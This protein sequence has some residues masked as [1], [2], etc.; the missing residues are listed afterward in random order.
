MPEELLPRM[1]QIFAE[2]KLSVDDAEYVVV[3][4]LLEQVEA[5]LALL[6][7]VAE[8]FLAAVV[9]KDEVTL[10]LP[11]EAWEPLRDQADEFEEARGYR[12]ITFDLPADLGVVGFIATLSSLLAEADVSLFSVSAYTRDHMLVQEEDLDQA[13]QVLSDFIQRC[14]DA[15]KESER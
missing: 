10:V 4:F 15:L 9:D 13:A 7:Q 11:W 3:G 6:S 14:Q 8:P 12:L 2:T 1:T 5:A